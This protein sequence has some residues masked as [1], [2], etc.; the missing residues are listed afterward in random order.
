MFP[1]KDNTKM[2]PGLRKEGFKLYYLSNFHIDIFTELKNSY[3][4]F[5]CFNG[6]IISAEVKH[7]KPDPAFYLILMEKYYLKAEECFFIDDTEV[8]IKTAEALGMKCFFTAGSISIS[9]H[10]L[11]RYAQ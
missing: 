2:L 11:M 3:S 8:N 6:G 7:S 9:L 5:K 1:L 4:F 10:Y